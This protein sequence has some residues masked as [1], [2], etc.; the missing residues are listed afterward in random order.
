MYHYLKGEKTFIVAFSPFLG[1]ILRLNLHHLEGRC[2]IRFLI[3]ATTHVHLS[4]GKPRNPRTLAWVSYY[5][6]V[7]I[8]ETVETLKLLWQFNMGWY[9]QCVIIQLIIYH[10]LTQI[11]CNLQKTTLWL[12]AGL[13]FIP[14][15]NQN[16]TKVKVMVSV[17]TF[18]KSKCYKVNI[19]VRR[20]VSV[21]TFS[22]SKQFSI[23]IFL[24]SKC[25]EN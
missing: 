12:E 21:Y 8:S 11:I 1:T 2:F 14:F 16:I 7:I 10:N 22:K 5:N 25:Y 24:K 9:L 6:T 15:Q 23:Y 13:V 20:E 4:K 19:K 3:L 17:H 18:L